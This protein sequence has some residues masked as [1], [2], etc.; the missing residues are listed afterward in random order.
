MTKFWSDIFRSF[1]FQFGFSIT[2]CLAESELNTTE[3]HPFEFEQLKNDF[4]GYDFISDEIMSPNNF[5]CL[6]EIKR[7]G[8][9]L[10]RMEPWAIKCI[11][12]HFFKQ[13]HYKEQT[14]LKYV[15]MFI[16]KFSG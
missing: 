6:N 5:Q 16:F 9:G 8:L 4:F 10:K 12:I 2:F 1:F 15:F 11:D 3:L 7:I 13:N 14:D